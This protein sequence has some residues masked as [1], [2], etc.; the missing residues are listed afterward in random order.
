M[1]EDALN[2]GANGIIAYTDFL[3]MTYEEQMAY[4]KSISAE[5][6]KMMY[7]DTLKVAQEAEKAAAE[8]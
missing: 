5:G 8:Y 2:W 4:L 1:A 3:A 6:A 7:E